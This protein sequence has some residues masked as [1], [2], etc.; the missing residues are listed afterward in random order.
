M[1]AENDALTEE[2]HDSEIL[3]GGFVR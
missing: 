2:Y 3:S 1:T